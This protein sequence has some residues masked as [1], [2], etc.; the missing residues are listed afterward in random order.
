MKDKEEEIISK[1]GGG[2]KHA[3]PRASDTGELCLWHKTGLW[4]S[5]QFE[6]RGMQVGG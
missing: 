4:A 5:Q 3:P 2:R 1:E 6:Q